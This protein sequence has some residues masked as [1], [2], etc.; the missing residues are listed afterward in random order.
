[1]SSKI[2]TIYYPE[3]TIRMKSSRNNTT[4]QNSKC[5]LSLKKPQAMV[6][7]LM[8]LLLIMSPALSLFAQPQISDATLSSDFVQS[9]ETPTLSLSYYSRWNTSLTPISSGAQ[10]IGDNIILNATWTPADFSNRTLIQ[11]NA[12]A[13]P[14]VIENDSNTSSVE[15]NTRSIGNNATCIINVTTW[16]TNGTEIFEMFYDIFLGNFFIPHVTVLTPN[17]GEV[18][19]DV[20]NITWHAWDNNTDETLTYDVLFSSDSGSSFQL[21][22]SGLTET[23]FEWNTSEFQK[24][25]SFLIE[26]RVQDGIYTN[27]DR[28]D[29]VFTAGNITSITTPPS[30][31]P[32]TTT[33]EPVPFDFRIA[34]F[35]A[36]AIMAAAILSMIVYYQAKS[37]F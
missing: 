26:V 16:L 12:T 33:T 18:W 37:Q 19:D 21:L 8:L 2:R 31:T 3:N 14:A 30:S 20:H 13:I 23:W 24:Q 35:V 4:F 22:T 5:V 17:G 10:L 27:F 11:V 28:S 25:N 29:S 34:T 6:P 1:L 7:L 32:T 15:I 36:A 9:A